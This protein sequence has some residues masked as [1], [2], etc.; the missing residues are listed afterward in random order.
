MPE[1]LTGY[2]PKHILVDPETFAI[3]RQDANENF[4]GNLNALIR[5]VLKKYSQKK[6]KQA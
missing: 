4:D 3:L 2:I 1:K 6:K 5:H